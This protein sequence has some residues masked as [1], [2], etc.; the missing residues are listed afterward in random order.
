MSTEIRVKQLKFRCSNVSCSADCCCPC[1]ASSSSSCFFFPSSTS[2]PLS[3]VNHPTSPSSSCFHFPRGARRKKK[4]SMPIHVAAVVLTQS[5]I[6]SCRLSSSLLHSVPFFRCCRSRIS[7]SWLSALP[8]FSYCCEHSFLLT[9]QKSLMSKI[10]LV[11]FIATLACI[12]LL[13]RLHLVSYMDQMMFR[14]T[15][16]SAGSN[17]VSAFPV[18]LKPLSP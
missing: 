6:F 11:H 12:I 16:I 15:A 3:L 17:F 2:E 7:G 9:T 4:F 5:R 8:K 1:V 10:D 14:D 18:R 13:H